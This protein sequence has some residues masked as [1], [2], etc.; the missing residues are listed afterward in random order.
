VTPKLH[1]EDFVPGSVTPYGGA[2][3]DRD[4]MLAFAREFDAQ[5]MHLSEEA[6]RG[7]MAGKLIASGWFTAALNMRM[8][9]EEFILDTASMGSPG[10]SELKW[11]KPVEA[12]DRLR[13][14]R[15]VIDRRPSLTRPDRGFVNFRFEVLNQR[16]EHVLEQTNLIMVG[17]RGTE[18]LEDAAAQPFG[19]GRPDLPEFRDVSTD[20]IPFFEDLNVG[21][22]LQLGSLHFAEADVIRFAK[23][24]D[25]QF[26]HVDPVAAKGSIFGG[27]IASGWHT[28][29][30]WMGQMVRSRTA[31]AAAALARGERPA[32]L[33]PSPGFKHLRWIRP[34]FAGDTITYT[35][36]IHEMRASASRPEWGIVRHYNTGVNQKG[37]TVFSFFG[38][39]FWERR[40]A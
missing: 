40:P 28:G 31:S 38:S 33:G 16:D 27:L 35:S 29:G 39:V 25:P 24:Y 9:A 3:V 22:R 37:Q 34:V 32:R 14:V 5:P 12:G 15:H 30:G 10:V 13:G 1:F 6:A 11:L 19:E 18:A 7:T 2:V 17:R 21:D 23:A 20:T 36:A 26:F 4:E 8:M